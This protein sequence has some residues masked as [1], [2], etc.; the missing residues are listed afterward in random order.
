MEYCQCG[1]QAMPGT[2][3]ITCYD[4]WCAEAE[5]RSRAHHETH[6]NEG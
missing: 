6:P 1:R 3:C 4:E 2:L 5:A